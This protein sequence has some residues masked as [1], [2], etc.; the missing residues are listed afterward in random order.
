MRKRPG[1]LA[2]IRSMRPRNLGQ[3]A[4]ELQAQIAKLEREAGSI[5]TVTA[6]TMMA[7]TTSYM[8]PVPQFKVLPQPPKELT[9]EEKVAKLVEEYQE[10]KED[11]PRVVRTAIMSH[12]PV[13]RQTSNGGSIFTW[14]SQLFFG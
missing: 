14:I 10:S 12:K 5:Q 2:G 11:S 7:P 13:T 8:A 6:P 3:T 1:F 9:T 4:D